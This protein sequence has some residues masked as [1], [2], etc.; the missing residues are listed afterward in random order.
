MKIMVSGREIQIA[1]FSGPLDQAFLDL[2][3]AYFGGGAIDW[4]RFQTV[5]EDFFSTAPN[6]SFWKDHNNYFE[7]FGNLW[8]PHL[9]IGRFEQAEKVWKMALEPALAVEK[10]KGYEIHK[11]TPFYFWGATAILKGDLDLG[12]ALM[13]QA[14]EEDK[15]TPCPSGY[16]NEPAY[17]FASL[18][19]EK[20]EQAFKSWVDEHSEFLRGLIKTYASTHNSK[21]DLAEFRKKFL[22]SPPTDDDLFWFTYCLARFKHLHDL[23]GYIVS[24]DFASIL[25]LNILSDFAVL[26]EDVL[27]H[28]LK[29]KSMLGPLL[30]NFLSRLKQPLCIGD[31]NKALLAGFESTLA[32]ILSGAFKLENGSGLIGHQNDVVIAYAIRNQALHNVFASGVIRQNFDTL[33]SALLNVLFAAVEHIDSVKP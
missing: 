30:E 12:F 19:V 25:Q 29:I 32:D 27:A 3:A 17:A 4:P 23:P 22:V 33:G 24:S 20:P 7:A 28:K 15:L 9:A 1:T 5:S 13:H 16:G 11:G 6:R 31:I 18:Q 10:H 21:F 8:R 26:L 14:I 2:Y